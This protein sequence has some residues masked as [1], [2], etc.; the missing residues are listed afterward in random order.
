M[1]KIL[2]WFIIGLVT[3]SFLFMALSLHINRKYKRLRKRTKAKD[4]TH[5]PDR[6]FTDP[7]LLVKDSPNPEFISGTGV[8]F[9]Q[10]HE[11]IRYNKKKPV[12]APITKEISHELD[13]ITESSNEDE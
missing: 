13:T 9:N 11:T 6:K 12:T 5:S 2:Y 1:H 8:H 4:P 10:V 3:M 7:M